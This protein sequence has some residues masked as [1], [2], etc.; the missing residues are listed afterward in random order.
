MNQNTSRLT[1]VE[2]LYFQTAGEQP[3]EAAHQFTR[4]KLLTEDQPCIR[5]LTV[6]QEWMAIDKCWLEQSGM[7]VVKNEAGMGRTTIPS[8]LELEATMKQVIEI[9]YD[10]GIAAHVQVYPG[11]TE[12]FHPIDFQKVR[13]RCRPF[14]TEEGDEPLRVL[15]RQ[16]TGTKV[17]VTVFPT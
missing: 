15:L 6:K 11:E 9:S 13:I 2:K 5:K 10:G 1:V 14:N 12:R 8:P 4:K 16:I 17:T 7:V 3:K